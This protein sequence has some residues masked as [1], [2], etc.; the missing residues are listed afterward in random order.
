MTRGRGA[1]Q[2]PKPLEASWHRRSS[3]LG[4]PSETSCALT[5]SSSSTASRSRESCLRR[6]LARS[7]ICSPSSLRRA[8]TSRWSRPPLPPA[9]A[10]TDDRAE[11]VNAA[12]V[13]IPIAIASHATA[14]AG[15]PQ[16][17]LLVA[18]AQTSPPVIVP[19]ARTEKGARRP[20]GTARSRPPCRRWSAPRQSG[21]GREGSIAPRSWSPYPPSSAPSLIRWCWE[22]FRRS[23]K[24]S[25]SR[26]RSAWPL[27]SRPSPL[28]RSSTSPRSS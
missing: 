4:Q 21:S 23:V 3:L 1:P 2:G 25:R 18:S 28:A 12:M 10:M 8:R 24:R 20:V 11:M 9:P 15:T 26:T 5:R 7:L 16:S 14:T 13:A 22:D 27:A 17:A 19:S 6:E